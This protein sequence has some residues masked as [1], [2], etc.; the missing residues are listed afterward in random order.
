MVPVLKRDGLMAGGLNDGTDQCATDAQATCP[1]TFW[2]GSP[3]ADQT[4][5][6]ANYIKQHGYKKVGILTE[7]L[8]YTQSESS[9]L[10][11]SLKADG[12][13]SDVVTFSATQVSL[14]PQVDE[15]KSAGADVM[16]VAAL[17]A[18]DGYATSARASLDYNVPIL[19]DL[20]S[21]SADITKLAPAS[22]LK[23][24]SEEIFRSNNA[25]LHL[26]GATA[27][28]ASTKQFG[29]I[30]KGGALDTLAYAWDDLVALHDAAAQAHA[31]TQ[32][33]LVAAEN[34][35]DTA[36]QSDPLYLLDPHVRW[37]S[38]DHDTVAA[39]PADYYFVPVGPLVNGQVKSASSQ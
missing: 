34:H 11:K 19:F 39:T 29:G 26:P 3:E 13:S 7:A 38:S 21:S 36:A 4:E 15:L 33:A 20:A 14:T 23:N 10:V 1:T 6:A 9:S 28:L 27:L 24:T 31:S 17:G 16:F 32:T 22:Q 37:T 25:A 18:P 5:A 2:L 8:A 35:L 12:V 30:P